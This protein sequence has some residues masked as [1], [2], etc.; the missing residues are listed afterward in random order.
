MVK[1]RW[2]YGPLHLVAE[3]GDKRSLCGVKDPAPCGLARNAWDSGPWLLPRYCV[4]CA[5]VYEA[6]HWASYP[7]LSLNREV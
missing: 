5:Q 2:P 4:A 7:A 6:A 3:A 1:K